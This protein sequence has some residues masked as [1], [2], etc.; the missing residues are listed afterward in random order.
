VD[1]RISSAPVKLP[2][3]NISLSSYQRISAQ[4]PISAYELMSAFADIS[5]SA[6]QRSRLLGL[7]SL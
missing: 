6:Y 3:M 4:C 1:K 5:L 2:Q 7:M